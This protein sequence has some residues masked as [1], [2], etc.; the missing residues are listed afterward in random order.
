M[1]LKSN[2]TNQIK[3]YKIEKL[4]YYKQL[5]IQITAYWNIQNHGSHVHP[6]FQNTGCKKIVPRSYNIIILPWIVRRGMQ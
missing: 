6:D 5:F 1:K 2:K 4:S 3:Q